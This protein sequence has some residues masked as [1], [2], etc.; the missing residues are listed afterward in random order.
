MPQGLSGGEAGIRVHRIARPAAAGSRS[1]DGR[2]WVMSGSAGRQHVEI[3]RVAGGVGGRSIRFFLHRLVVG[4]EGGADL[5]Q[6]QPQLGSLCRCAVTSSSG[7]PSNASTPTMAT[8][9]TSSISVKPVRLRRRHAF[10]CGGSPGSV[11]GGQ[12]RHVHR[13]PS[14]SRGPATAG[15]AERL[16]F[17]R[18][19]NGVRLAAPGDAG[20][21]TQLPR[22]IGRGA[23]GATKEFCVR[24]VRSLDV[25]EDA[26][27]TAV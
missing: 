12:C 8:V 4:V 13:T 2:G 17:N 26:R 21:R 22:L 23:F 27:V 15:S 19:Q 24:P 14:A 3:R 18:R 5:P 10:N 11:A 25:A 7:V 16:F 9:M 6:R 20:E 1:C